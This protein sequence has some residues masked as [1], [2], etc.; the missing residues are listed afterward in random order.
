VIPDNIHAL[1]WVASWNSKAMGDYACWNSK[2]MWGASALNFQRGKKVK[3]SQEIAD[4]LI[5][6]VNKSSTEAG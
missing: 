3:S 1:P 5:F 6:L 4:L 2:C